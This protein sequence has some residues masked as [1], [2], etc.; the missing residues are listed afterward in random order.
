LK[1]SNKE[2]FEKLQKAKEFICQTKE[3]SAIKVMESIDSREIKTSNYMLDYAKFLNLRGLIY[4]ENGYN[5]KA[6][7]NFNLASIS[8][9]ELSQDPF[10]PYLIN[11]RYDEIVGICLFSNK[12]DDLKNEILELISKSQLLNNNF[13]IIKGFLSLANIY[14]IAGNFRQGYQIA[15]YTWNLAKKKKFHSDF[16]IGRIIYLYMINIQLNKNTIFKD[17]VFQKINSENNDL[18]KNYFIQLEDKLKLNT[19]RDSKEKDMNNQ[20]NEPQNKN[21][22]MNSNEKLTNIFQHPLYISQALYFSSDYFYSK[23]KLYKSLFLIEKAIEYLEKNNFNDVHLI[24]YYVKKWIILN[25][26]GREATSEYIVEYTQ[27][28]I[29]Q[30]YNSDSTKNLEYLR[31]IQ[32]NSSTLEPP[33][34]DIVNEIASKTKRVNELNNVNGLLNR[35]FNIISLINIKSGIP[36]L[37][38]RYTEF[39]ELEKEI[40][41]GKISEL[42]TDLKW[43]LIFSKLGNVLKAKN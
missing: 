9:K 7:T 14:T 28:L 15:N 18:L 31:Y 17:E 4:Y 34:Q 30:F 11:N 43:T 41:S 40:F 35:Y 13:L 29:S 26:M 37:I 6:I 27:K 38:D 1:K 39:D 5:A 42:R 3:L 12:I 21:E 23:R 36:E 24:L 16:L 32:I 8:F 33:R 2:L 10:D 19:D 20:E 22:N 25:Q